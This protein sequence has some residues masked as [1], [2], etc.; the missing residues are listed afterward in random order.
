MIR[1]RPDLKLALSVA[2]FGLPASSLAQDYVDNH[3]C[4]LNAGGAGWSSV[5]GSDH[6][7]L[8]GGWEQLSIGAGIG[9]RPE[10]GKTWRWLV[11]VNFSYQALG[12]TQNAITQSQILNPLNL[13]LE[14]ANNGSAK[15]YGFT[16][17]PVIRFGKFKH[18]KLYAFAGGGWFRRSLDFTSSG[19]GTVLQPNSRTVYSTHSDSGSVD[20]GGGV[21]IKPWRSGFTPYVEA[22]VIHGL[23]IN[24]RTTLVPISVGVR[25]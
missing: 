8:T 9:P 1:K 4:T 13:A 15:A 3:T 2:L 10:L 21:N 14:E 7:S 19:E 18:F 25:W 23:A 11:T 24:S 16:L 5:Q 12:I 6:G 22:R 17:D 20:G